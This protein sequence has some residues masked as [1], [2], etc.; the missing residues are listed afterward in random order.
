MTASS[1]TL[2]RM[3]DKAAEP[4]DQ[5]ERAYLALRTDVKRFVA[6]RVGPDVVDDLAQ[7]IFLRMHE[8]ATE[9]R[10][11][12]RV[13]PWLFRIARSVVVDHLRKRRIHAPLDAAEEPATEEPESNFNSEMAAWFRP[14]IEMLPEEYRTALV[15]TEIE[16]I[17]Q[18]ELADRA[19]LSL[20]G[21]KSR[22]QRGKQMLEGI[23]RACCDFEVDTRGNFVACSPRSGGPCRSC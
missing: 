10:D 17:T 9:L 21:A 7:E 18:R 6:R 20:S 19:G 22:V 11:A 15:L 12:A 2:E 16:G 4:S 14:M 23:V 1:A 3:D 8:H 13:A 5:L